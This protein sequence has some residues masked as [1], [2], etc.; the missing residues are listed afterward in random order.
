MSHKR[1][2]DGMLRLMGDRGINQT[3]LCER[4]HVSRSTLRKIRE[5]RMDP[6]FDILCRLSGPLGVHWSRLVELMYG[7]A[8]Q[9]PVRSRRMR[10]LDWGFVGPGEDRL[11]EWADTSPPEWCETVFEIGNTGSAPWVGFSLVNVNE[12]SDEDYWEPL[13][14][15]IPLGRVRDEDEWA[16]IPP[17]RYGLSDGDRAQA[18]V[19]PGETTQVSLRFKTPVQRRSGMSRWCFVDA[20][21]H[22]LYPQ[23]DGMV[24]TAAPLGPK[25]SVYIFAPWRLVPPGAHR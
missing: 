3:Q 4:A 8:E 16:K 24:V 20:H 23:L 22:L 10:A 7:D 11:V 12:P 13:R 19:L 21:K 6:S 9:D 1:L 25:E 14:P 2:W 5:A 15:W 17:K 18:L